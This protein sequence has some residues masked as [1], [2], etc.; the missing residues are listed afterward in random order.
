MSREESSTNEAI[1]SGM[2]VLADYEPDYYP[3]FDSGINLPSNLAD[4]SPHDHI[5]SN[6]PELGLKTLLD[7]DKDYLK[8]GETSD[9]NA[10]SFH[11]QEVSRLNTVIGKLINENFSLRLGEKLN[12]S[13]DE[14]VCE[15]N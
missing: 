15:E 12:D 6:K 7:P 14:T 2:N 10:Y 13:P 3:S 9:Q 1:V 11:K 4:V 8:N 5:V